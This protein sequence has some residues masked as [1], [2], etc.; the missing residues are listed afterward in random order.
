MAFITAALLVAAPAA[1]SNERLALTLDARDRPLAGRAISL[2]RDTFSLHRAL[3]SRFPGQQMAL[4]SAPHAVTVA[5][6]VSDGA[7]EPVMQPMRRARDAGEPIV[8]QLGMAAQAPVALR[9]R[10][11]ELSR[12]G[13]AELGIAGPI[14]MQAA[15]IVIHRIGDEAALPGAGNAAA[16]LPL[17]TRLDLLSRQGLART[18]A[19]PDLL[20]VSGAPARFVSGGEVPVAIAQPGDTTTI[21][22]EPF[23]LSLDLLP[24]MLGAGR[25]TLRV[26]LTI[27]RLAD[28]A[29]PFDTAAGTP[30]FTRPTIETT[31]EMARGQTLVI[32]GLLPAPSRE[33]M[34]GIA[35]LGDLPLLGALFS[36]ETFRR[37]DSDLFVTVTPERIDKAG[38]LRRREATMAVSRG[39]LLAVRAERRDGAGPTDRRVPRSNIDTDAA[40]VTAP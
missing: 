4:I 25:M 34:N 31:V 15:G 37:G 19:E 39:A 11:I 17:A 7:V 32:G 16:R 20:T 38:S 9:L 14:A 8:D 3:A 26:R 29:T 30:I 21:A 27:S 28:P 2:R 6:A 5:G 24:R 13:T 18:L 36:S 23:G 35:G 12:R 33:A 22:F 40:A 10:V 1:Q